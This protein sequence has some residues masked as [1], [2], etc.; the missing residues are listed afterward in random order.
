[1]RAIRRV[2]V[3]A[4]LM[5]VFLLPCAGIAQAAEKS[6]KPPAPD[7]HAGGVQPSSIPNDATTEVTLP[8]FHLTG[9]HMTSGEQCSVVSTTVVSDNEIK[10]KIK[11][12]R[13]TEDKDSQCTLT[14][15][16]PGGTAS[17]WIVIELTDAEQQEQDAQTRA[18]EMKAAQA[19][20]QRSGKAWH[21][22][23][24]NGATE[25]YTSTGSNDDG[26]PVFENQAGTSVKI[27]VS[28]DNIVMILEQDCMRSGKL[29]GNQV[30][31]GQ[32]QGAC[33]PPG[34]WTATVSQ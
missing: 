6:A 14:V 4:A 27:M 2:A 24:A 16:T 20:M 1:M 31:N 12:I 25:S 30:K 15:H 8:G 32:S 10:M 19:F 26:A 33:S 9:A 23:F 28:N 18:T 21:L 34:S 17:T 29:A 5:I 13:K 3:C 7:L 11:G 22:V